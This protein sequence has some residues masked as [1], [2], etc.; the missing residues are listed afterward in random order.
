VNMQPILVWIDPSEQNSNRSKDLIDAIDKNSAFKFAGFRKQSTDVSF[1]RLVNVEL[2]EPADLVQSVLNGHLARQVIAMQSEMCP[3]FIVCLGSLSDALETITSITKR[4][5]RSVSDKISDQSRVR[6]F[7]ADSFAYNI[8]VFFWDSQPMHWMLSH[9]YNILTSGDITS[10]LPKTDR[11]LP[12]IA[13]LCMIPGV[14]KSVARGLINRYGSIKQLCDAVAEDPESI[15][16]TVIGKR[17][18][19]SKIALN[20]ADMLTRRY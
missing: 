14:G 2:K 8:P 6:A 16:D 5:R 4:G 19:G 7:C 11:E 3:A 1:D 18:I 15:K 9:V 20:V 12:A 10:H 13:M 17:R